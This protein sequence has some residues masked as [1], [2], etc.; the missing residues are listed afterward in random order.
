MGKQLAYIDEFGNSGL[1]IG[2]PGVSSHFIITAILVDDDKAESISQSVEQ[3]RKKHFQTSEIKSSKVGSNHSRRIKIL[4]DIAE[5]DIQTFT[6]VIDKSKLISEGYKYKEVFYKNLPRI[7][8]NILIDTFPDIHI[9]ADEH[10]SNEFML[11]FKKYLKNGFQS[12][13]FNSYEFYFTDSKTNNIVQVADFIA[14]TIARGFDK[15]KYTIKSKDFFEI[16]KDNTY[17]IREWPF[18]RKEPY[19]LKV[20]SHLPDYDADIANYSLSIARSFIKQNES[21][22]G[23]R[24][25]DQVVFLKYLMFNLIY[26]NPNKFIPTWEILKHINHSRK[27]ELT[28]HGFRNLVGQLRDRNIIISSNGTG[29]KLPTCEGD[30]IH[31]V[32]HY[33]HYIQPMLDRLDKCRKSILM[34]TKKKMDILDKP[35]YE[36]LKKLLDS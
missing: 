18:E 5:L 17:Q 15:E 12:D 6:I 24:K 27:T 7:I 20:G 33:N 30:L 4:K 10:G 26:Y 14:G 35:E 3:I 19:L 9:S 11:S 25:Q 36:N 34:L 29:Y 21:S 2:Q 28:M 16:I 13:L 22:K 8:L 23:L 31:F 32:N 1:D